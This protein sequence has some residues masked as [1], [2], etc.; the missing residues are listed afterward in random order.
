MTHTMLEKSP[1]KYARIAGLLYLVIAVFGAFAIGY[2]PSVIYAAG[3]AAQTAENLLANQGLFNMGVLADVVVLQV[4][5]ILTVMLY[6]LFKPVSPTLSMIAT[7]SRFGMIVVMGMNILI[8]IMPTLLLSG[9]NVLAVFDTAQLQATAFMFFEAHALGIF[10]WQLFFSLH[11]LLVGYLVVKSEY[12]PKVLGWMM[13]VGSFGYLIQ[14]L[15]G[16]TQ[17]ENGLVST[18]VVV[19]LVLVTLGELGFALWLLIKGINVQKFT[20]R[21]NL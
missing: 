13:G 6:W 16:I 7:L 2:V 19:L 3:D 8:H 21:T 9:S 18:A 15:A 14:A 5:I 11:L 17:T 20:A 10:I 12:F 1:V 4:E